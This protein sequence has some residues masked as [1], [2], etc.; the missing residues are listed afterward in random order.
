MVGIAQ[1][2]DSLMSID[3]VQI[4]SWYRCFGRM[5]CPFLP[6]NRVC[7]GNTEVIMEK[8]LDQLCR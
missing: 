2:I 6:H 5:C 7:P 8:K 4:I 1:M 3:T